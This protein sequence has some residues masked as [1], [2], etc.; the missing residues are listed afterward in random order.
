MSTTWSYG[1]HYEQY[2][3][4]TTFLAIEGSNIEIHL[5]FTLHFVSYFYYLFHALILVAHQEY[6]LNPKAMSLGEL[7]GENDLSTNEWTDGVLSSLMR[8]ACAGVDTKTQ[9][10]VGTDESDERAENLYVAVL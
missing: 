5:S 1:T 7:Y 2:Y 9:Y 10:I 3:C 4:D 8:S 6:P